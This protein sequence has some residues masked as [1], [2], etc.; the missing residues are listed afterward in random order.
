MA[1]YLDKIGLK[2]LWKKCK[3]LTGLSATKLTTGSLD[4]VSMGLFSLYYADTKNTCTNS[5]V[6]TYPF[7]MIASRISASAKFQVAFYP[8][9]NAIYMRSLA[10]GSWTAWRK[11]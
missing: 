1:A 4:S 7:L 8:H 5:A 6:A 10:A 9:N 11:I 2:E 3:A